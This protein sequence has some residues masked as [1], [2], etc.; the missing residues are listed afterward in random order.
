MVDHQVAHERWR[1]VHR[2]VYALSAAP[3]S[4]RQRWM[5]ATLTLP[6]T[7][8]SHA[9]AAA[10]WGFRPFDGTFETVSRPGGGGPRQIAKLL[11][12]RSRTLSGDTTR[13]LGI[14]ITTPA[15]TLIDLAPHIDAA[16]TGRAVREAVRLEVTTMDEIAAT[17]DRHPLR[18]GTAELG[19]R[20]RRY[21]TLPYARTRSPAEAR[22]LE[23]LHDAG[24]EIPL[25]NER[26]AGEEA[27]LIWPHRRRIVEIDG[28][29]YHRF[30]DEDARK[31]AHW[32]AAGWDVRR[33]PSDA[34]FN[35][36]ARLVALA[37]SRSSRV[38]P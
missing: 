19:R 21:R 29:D 11:V 9:S 24:V 10:C 4:R 38:P 1:V 6:K 12:S 3:L 16:A 17:L 26:I 30:R 7:Y 37:R 34:V 25:V 20:V 35:D 28:P 5:A 15:R 18:R 27:D 14:P 32:R 36:P 13:H 2:G 31:E 23:V 33:I 22:A 8:L